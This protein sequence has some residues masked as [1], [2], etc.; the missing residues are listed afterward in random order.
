MKQQIKISGMSCGGCVSSVKKAL[1]QLD[2]AESVEVTLN[3]P[4]ATIT[5]DA[6][7]TKDDLTKVLANAGNYAIVEKNADENQPE[8]DGSCCC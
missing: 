7:Y 8:S 4:V 1:E 3:P 2:G 5:S 6:T